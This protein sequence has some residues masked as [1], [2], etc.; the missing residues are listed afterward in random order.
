MFTALSVEQGVV[1]PTANLDEP[2]ADIADIDIVHGA[3][4]SAPVPV[5]VSNSF[6]FGG[7]NAVVVLGRA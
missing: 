2:G 4:R 3:P 6:G 5:A 7:H 1:P